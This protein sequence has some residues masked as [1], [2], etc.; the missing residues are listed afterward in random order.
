MCLTNTQLKDHIAKRDLI[1]IS[2]EDLNSI[3][4]QG[5]PLAYSAD[6]LLLR[7]V[8]DFY[9]DGLSLVRRCDI[10][11]SYHRKT[12]QFQRKLLET[13]NLLKRDVFKSNYSV[14][15]YGAFLGNLPEDEIVILEIESPKSRAFYIGRVV[16][17]NTETITIQEF[18]GAGNWKRQETV[19]LT[20]DITFCQIQTN[21]INF[22]SRHFERSSQSP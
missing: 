22:Y 8:H 13:E 11:D 14:E 19:V 1:A 3:K 5:F 6:L 18:T 20:S 15:N 4:M 9:L 21:Y 7:H 16:S 17:I 12:D 2:R 10:T